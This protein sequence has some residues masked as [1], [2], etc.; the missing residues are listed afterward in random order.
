MQGMQ[1][2][3]PQFARTEIELY[4]RIYGREGT[5]APLFSLYPPPP[6]LSLLTGIFPWLFFP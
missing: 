3:S 5:R 2:G 1:C 4:A 6:P